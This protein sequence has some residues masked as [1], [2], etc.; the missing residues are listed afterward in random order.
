MRPDTGNLP[1]YLGVEE[2]IFP[3]FEVEPPL[4]YFAKLGEVES[5]QINQQGFPGRAYF[6]FPMEGLEG[7]EQPFTLWLPDCPD[8]VYMLP[9]VLIPV[10]KPAEPAESACSADLGERDCIAAG[11]TYYPINDTTSTC[12]CP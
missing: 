4:P 11:G 3:G 8:P 12:I 6:L 10:P 7:T 9:A 2:G 5:L 1:V